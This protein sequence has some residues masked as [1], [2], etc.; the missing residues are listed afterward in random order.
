MI[1]PPLVASRGEEGTEGSGGIEGKKGSTGAGATETGSAGGWL[2]DSDGSGGGSTFAEAS[3]DASAG[4]VPGEEA[5][6][7]DSVATGDSAETGVGTV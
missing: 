3:M 2:G 5:T 6:L 7:A 4:T 1:L